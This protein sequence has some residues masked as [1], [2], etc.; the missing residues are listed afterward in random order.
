MGIEPMEENHQQLIR[1][2]LQTQ[3]L[4]VLATSADG[5]PYTTLIGFAA[6]DNLAEIYF[7]T[8]RSTRKF[9]N[10]SHDERTT[11]L[12][13]NRSNQPVDFRDVFGVRACET[14]IGSS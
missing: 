7:A 12:I 9:A 14:E 10:L 4:G 1:D 2:L 13:N 8:H 3:S 11:L 6:G 5:H